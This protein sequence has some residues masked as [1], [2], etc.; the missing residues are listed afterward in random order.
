MTDILSHIAAYKREEV[1]RLRSERGEA[2]LLRAA[3]E[4]APPRGFARALRE[5]DHRP[6]LIAEIKKASPSKGLI[7]EDFDPASLAQA[8]AE[9]GATCLSCLTDGPS[10][11]G[12]EEGLRAARGA[13]DLPV[14][15]KDFTLDPV[16]VMEARAMG[17]DAVLIIMAM[18]DDTLNAEL[19]AA[20]GE[21]GLDALVETHT[22]AE[23][24]RALMLDA[25]IIGINNRNLSSFHTTLD[26]FT[27]LASRVPEN[28]LRIAES[29]IFTRAD[30]ERVGREGADAMLVGESLMRE[31]DVAGAVRKLIGT[32]SD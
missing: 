7:R 3:E 13:V 25:R 26:T 4:Q 1:A 16:Q 30:A 23:I 22:E 27:Q 19:L 9:G 6:A 29:G 31:E 17:A 10:F 2:A 21:L 28:R 11:G 20:A 32:D 15:R 8:Y 5:A 14:L 24:E 18:T 12:S